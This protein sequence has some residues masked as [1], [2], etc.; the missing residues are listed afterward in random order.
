M[1]QTGEEKNKKNVLLELNKW[2][3]KSGGSVWH[4]VVWLAVGLRVE[5]VFDCEVS[6]A[7]QTLQAAHRSDKRP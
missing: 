2:E 7:R 1:M 4:S 5:G 6:V 3:R